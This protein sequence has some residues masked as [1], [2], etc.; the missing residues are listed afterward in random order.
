MRE[1]RKKWKILSDKYVCPWKKNKKLTTTKSG[2]P[3]GKK[4]PAFY[5]FLSTGTTYKTPGHD[6]KVIDA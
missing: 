3:G 5:L 2:Y 6:H 4:V 1:C